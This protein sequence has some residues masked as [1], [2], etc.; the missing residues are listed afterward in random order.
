MWWIFTCFF[1]MCGNSIGRFQI[2]FSRSD[3][4]TLRWLMT[5]MRWSL[6]CSLFSVDTMVVSVL[7][8]RVFPPVLDWLFPKIN[9]QFWTW[10]TILSNYLHYEQILF[11]FVGLIHWLNPIYWNSLTHGLFN[12]YPNRICLVWETIMFWGWVWW[13]LVIINITQM[14]IGKN[15]NEYIYI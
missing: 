6:V 5:H 14:E 13:I 3:Y 1:A 8:R 10:K 4:E 7:N 12:K 11:L 15:M 2:Q 9:S